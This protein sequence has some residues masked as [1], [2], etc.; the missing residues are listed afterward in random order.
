MNG[1]AD[2]QDLRL[3]FDVLTKTEQPELCRYWTTR[4]RCWRGR[5]ARAWSRDGSAD[6]LIGSLD[7]AS[8]E[9]GLSA[10]T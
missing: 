8:V 5:R 4:G 6:V 3:R 2:E 7:V 9:G 10:T 1:L